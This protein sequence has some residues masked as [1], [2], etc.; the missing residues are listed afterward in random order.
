M[1]GAATRTKEVLQWFDQ[2]N[3]LGGWTPSF[4]SDN[5]IS[6]IFWTIL[7]LKGVALTLWSIRAAFERYFEYHTITSIDLMSV[8]SNIGIPLPAFAICNSNR[9]HC[10]NLFNVINNIEKVSNRSKVTF[11]ASLVSGLISK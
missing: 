9:V 8:D 2:N 6:R 7:F 5:K 4:H 11:R 10:K 1:S 3:T